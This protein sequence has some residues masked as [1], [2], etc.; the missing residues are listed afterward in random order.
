MQNITEDSITS[1]QRPG[2]IFT[3]AI[4]AEE[5]PNS[6][7]VAT[8]RTAWGL[9]QYAMMGK[10]NFV[11]FKMLRRKLKRNSIKVL[12]LAASSNILTN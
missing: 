7:L 5:C 10:V 1:V 8:G 12:K 4:D 2:V 9:L 11:S 3:F 6:G